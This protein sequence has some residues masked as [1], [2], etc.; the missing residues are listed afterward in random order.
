MI[1]IDNFKPTLNC[2]K[3]TYRN[4]V[5]LKV[6]FSFR[7][8]GDDFFTHSNNLMCAVVIQDK[9]RLDGNQ[10]FDLCDN[11]PFCIVPCKNIVFSINS[12]YVN[13]HILVKI[14][15]MTVDPIEYSFKGF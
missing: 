4:S 14:L 1:L 8:Q 7:I 5:Y 9:N 12:P 15:N 11:L 6:Y 13:K 3:L 10:Y 2:L